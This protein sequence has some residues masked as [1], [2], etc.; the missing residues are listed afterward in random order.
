MTNM[1]KKPTIDDLLDEIENMVQCYYYDQVTGDDSSYQCDEM[2]CSVFKEL[3]P[4]RFEAAVARAEEEI[5][6][7]GLGHLLDESN[8]KEE[9]DD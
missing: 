2:I 1:R 6:E 9:T 3:Y 5:I 8:D 7:Q 4:E